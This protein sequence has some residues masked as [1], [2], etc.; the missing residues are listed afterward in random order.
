[1]GRRFNDGVTRKRRR[2]RFVCVL[3]ASALVTSLVYFEQVEII[4]V[5]SVLG[6]CGFLLVVAFSDLDRD[7]RQAAAP[8]R[9]VNEAAMVV[10]GTRAAAASVTHAPLKRGAAKRRHGVG[11]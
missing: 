7:A 5:L 4:Y 1:M 3:A 6:L 8:A 9:E 2:V 11:A 10:D